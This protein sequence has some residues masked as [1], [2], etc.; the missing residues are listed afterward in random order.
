VSL[1][2][3]LGRM[4]PGLSAKERGILL[5]RAYKGDVPEDPSWKNTTPPEQVDEVNHYIAL[6]NACNI[7]L[8]SFLM[9]V[10]LLAEQDWLRFEWATAAHCIVSFAWDISSLVPA[11]KRPQVENIVARSRVPVDLPW[12]CDDGVR[13]WLDL[14]DELLDSVS[15]GVRTRWAEVRAA[16]MLADVAAEAFGGEDPLRPVTRDLLE[17]TKKRVLSLHGLISVMRE[18]ELA[19]PDE[20][21]RASL[22][23]YVDR[24]K[25]LFS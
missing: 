7:H 5:L 1:D 13:S 20:E 22:R 4:M 15:R 19:E 17:G 11:G 8:E 10:E 2:A 6:C 12:N 16:E 24:G 21:M 3:R 25:R 9:Q 23:R 18:C 14:T